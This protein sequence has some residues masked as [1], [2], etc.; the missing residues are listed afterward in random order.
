M[1]LYFIRDSSLDIVNGM[2]GEFSGVVGP[3]GINS[4]AAKFPKTL[5]APFPIKTVMEN[6]HILM[7]RHQQQKIIEMM[8]K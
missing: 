3:F 5:L 2:Q 6:Q 7:N 1:E 8:K 4:E